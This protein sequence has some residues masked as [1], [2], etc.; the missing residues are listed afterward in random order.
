LG[1]L[2]THISY[3]QCTYQD[4]QLV[5]LHV[6]EADFWDMSQSVVS[7]INHYDIRLAIVLRYF[8]FLHH[9]QQFDIIYTIKIR[10]VR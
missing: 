5:F 8:Y 3:Y 2:L 9:Y 1:G 10:D 4:A 7:Q 6:C